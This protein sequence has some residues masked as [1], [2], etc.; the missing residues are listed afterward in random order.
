MKSLE[1]L[2]S[3][4]LCAAEPTASTRYRVAQMCSVL[5]KLSAKARCVCTSLGLTASLLFAAAAH[6]VAVRRP[7][8]QRKA[9]N[10]CWGEKAE[11]EL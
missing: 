3:R 6:M 11:Q 1:S 8:E 4:R 10:S 7:S 5:T 9:H 2:E